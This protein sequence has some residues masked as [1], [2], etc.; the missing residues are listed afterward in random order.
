MAVPVALP[1]TRPSG[2]AVVPWA[3]RGEHTS[4]VVV[5]RRHPPECPD[6]GG[7]PEAPGRA[8]E[9]SRARL[10][11]LGIVAY[12]AVFPLLQVAV[13]CESPGLGYGP[14]A[15]AAGADR[16]STRLNSSHLVISYAVFCLKKNNGQEYPVSHHSRRGP[17]R[18]RV[19]HPARL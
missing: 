3:P 14:G 10:A 9:G 4:S 19:A 17:V 5:T 15:W 13:I 6:R 7:A 18:Y 1:L 2:R 12:A 8:P 11:D 16:K